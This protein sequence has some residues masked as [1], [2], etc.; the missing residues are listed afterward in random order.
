MIKL[1]ARLQR[2]F[3]MI[4]LL[5]VIAIIGVLAAA[6]LAAI[7]P[8]EQI[9]KGRDAARRLPVSKGGVDDILHHGQRYLLLRSSGWIHRD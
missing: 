3:T 5:V 6:V 1:K 9:S 8:V 2:G 4:E 7:N